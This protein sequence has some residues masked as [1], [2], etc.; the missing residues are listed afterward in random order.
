VSRVL[1]AGV[2]LILLALTFDARVLLVPGAAVI[3]LGAAVPLWIRIAARG[4]SVRRQLHG[5]RVVE[6]QPLEATIEV[7]WG[8]LGLPGGEVL[9]EFTGGTMSL[10]GRRAPGTRGAR[11]TVRVVARFPRRG[12]RRFEPPS[13]WL[14]DPLG[15]SRVRRSGDGPVEELLVLPRTESVN[16]LSEEFGKLPESAPAAAAA[17]AFAAT[18]VDGLRPY[19]PGAPASRI[20]WPAVARGAG[21]LERRLRA[22]GASGPMVVLDARC[23]GPVE[24]LDAAVRAAASLVL[25]LGRR[26]GCELLLP[27]ERRPLLVGPDMAA[28]PAI[29]A[30]LAVVEGAADAPPPALSRRPRAGLIYYVLA[31]RPDRIERLPL[32]LRLRAVLVVPAALARELGYSPIFDVAGCRAFV[33]DGRRARDPMLAA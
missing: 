15:L 27:G 4:T 32:E 20:H 33:L 22:D 31:D 5:A 28:W 30:R 23:S 21:L 8:P 14:H 1:I 9:D 6:E 13:A 11:S 25:E 12:R 7:R 16:W 24:L 17:E 10:S 2:V 19:R 3:V 29:H 26:S 18:E